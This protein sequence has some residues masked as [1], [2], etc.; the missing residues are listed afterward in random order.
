MP[1]LPAAGQPAI[2]ADLP[3]P[4]VIVS[5]SIAFIIATYAG[6]TT[7]PGPEPVRS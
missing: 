6:W 2:A 5:V 7:W 1:V 4:V 3:V